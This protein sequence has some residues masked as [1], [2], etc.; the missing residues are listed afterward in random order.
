MIVPHLYAVF[1]KHGDTKKPLLPLS[2]AGRNS[3]NPASP[4]KRT[5]SKPSSIAAKLRDPMYLLHAA[6]SVLM[7]PLRPPGRLEALAALSLA[8]LLPLVLYLTTSTIT[9]SATS[10][11]STHQSM[12][13]QHHPPEPHQI[14]PL[15]ENTRSF[16][17]PPRKVQLHRPMDHE[18]SQLE[19]L[20][21]ETGSDFLRNLLRIPFRRSS[22]LRRQKRDYASSE[23]ALEGDSDSQDLSIFPMAPSEIEASADTDDLGLEREIFKSK[24][25]AASSRDG[26]KSHEFHVPLRVRASSQDEASDVFEDVLTPGGKIPPSPTRHKLEAHPVARI[27][28]NIFRKTHSKSL[29]L[30][31]C[32]AEDASWLRPLVQFLELDIPTFQF[33]CL[34]DSAELL[35]AA[36]KAR[37]AGDKGADG[38][39]LQANFWDPDAVLPRADLVVSFGGIEGVSSGHMLSFLTGLGE[40]TGCENALVGHWPHVPRDDPARADWVASLRMHK[41]HTGMLH[42][43]QH[44]P[45]MFPLPKRSFEGLDPVLPQKEMLWYRTESMRNRFS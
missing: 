21:G 32:R 27:V 13:M 15:P 45:F 2:A 29:I 1:A 43:L 19:R 22:E 42:N 12:Q 7:R 35:E 20:L 28:Y 16:R 37:V 26:V 34:A 9:F 3:E 17:H 36:R 41:L 31:P 11:R 33:H 44:P 38:A 39:Y 23:S 30:A 40:R 6:R 24:N 8:F 4:F 18:G 5:S 14:W 25:R 10:V